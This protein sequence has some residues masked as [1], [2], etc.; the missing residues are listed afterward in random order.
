MLIDQVEYTVLAD[1][2][3]RVLRTEAKVRG[4]REENIGLKMQLEEMEKKW[5]HYD[6]RMKLMEKGWQDQFSYIQVS[7]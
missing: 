7:R 2:E 1:L 4:R 3:K 6:E 5:K